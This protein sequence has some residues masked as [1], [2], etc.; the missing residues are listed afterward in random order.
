VVC[1]EAPA[2]LAAKAKPRVV[3]MK[4]RLIMWASENQSERMNDVYKL[5]I[6]VPGDGCLF[7][8]C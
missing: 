4:V 5:A 6:W 3:L 7:A 2:K 8:R 1:A